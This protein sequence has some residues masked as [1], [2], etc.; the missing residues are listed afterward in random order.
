M[1]SVYI[2]SVLR[3]DCLSNHLIMIRLCVL[4]GLCAAVASA[5]YYPSS[6]EPSYR[7]HYSYEPSYRQPYSYDP[8]YPRQ[9]YS[10]AP[11]YYPR[12]SYSYEPSY[13]PRQS[14]S[15]YPRHPYSYEPAYY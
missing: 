3:A 13:Y 5:Q 14:Y 4:L 2:Q 10:Y 6:Y 8:Y 11:A 15:Y 9:S 1:G 12:Q 7:Q